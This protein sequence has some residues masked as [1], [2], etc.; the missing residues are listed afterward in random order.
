MAAMVSSRCGMCTCSH[1]P[2]TEC[3]VYTHSGLGDPDR[4]KS[5]TIENKVFPACASK[6]YIHGFFY[7][8]IFRVDITVRGTI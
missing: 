1:D 8:T 6:F 2:N 5:R 3:T 7:S 4:K